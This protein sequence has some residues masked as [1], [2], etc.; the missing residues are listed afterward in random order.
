MGIDEVSA[1]GG[2]E[3]LDDD[4]HDGVTSKSGARFGSTHTKFRRRPGAATAPRACAK[5]AS[6]GLVSM[7]LR[8]NQ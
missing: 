8:R 5:P 7:Q 3:E 1:G 4:A 2:I 6:S